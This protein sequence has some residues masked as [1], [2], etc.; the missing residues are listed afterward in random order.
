[1]PRVVPSQ[2]VEF[3]DSKFPFAR[4]RQQY[5]VDIQYRGRVNALLQLADELPEELIRMDSADY[6]RFVLS[7][8]TIR[9]TLE[10]EPW[11]SRGQL[12]E[13]YGRDLR[14]A[15]SDL[16]SCV[17]PLP[18][19]Q[20]PEA[21]T[22]LAFIEDAPL[23][24]SIRA[25][26]TFANQ[27]FSGGEW[28]ATTVLAGAAAEALLLWAITERK[29]RSEVENARGAVISWARKDPNTWVLDGYIKVAKTLELIEAETEKQAELAR[30][31]RDLIHPGRAA[32][33]AKKCDRGTALSA[34]A[35]MELIVRDL[36]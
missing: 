36:S 19:Q 25:D 35:A 4:T 3:I 10:L 24:E 34:L 27:E 18:D 15:I 5:N 1:M 26:I 28:K 12:A 20:I 13:L 22:G 23:R 32:R 2:I 33:L 21:T 6:N 16:R 31:F 9:S 8:S 17:D 14:D 11:I 30:G 7:L 29:S